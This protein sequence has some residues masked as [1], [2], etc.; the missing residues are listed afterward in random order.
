MFMKGVDRAY[1]YLAY[2][3]LPRKIVKWTK[4]VALWLINCALFNSLLVYRNLNP[5]SKLKYKEFL[6]Q[7]E[8]SWATDEIEAAHTHRLSATLTINSHPM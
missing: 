1:Q 5:G 6:L 4:K 8:K 2:Y 7:V 3:S